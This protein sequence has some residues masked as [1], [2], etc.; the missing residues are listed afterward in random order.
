MIQLA[1]RVFWKTP[2]S[3]PG[4]NI[5]RGTTWIAPQMQVRSGKR[6]TVGAASAATGFP[7]KARRG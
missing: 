7:G 3:V 2:L 5:R 1:M 4:A 6:F